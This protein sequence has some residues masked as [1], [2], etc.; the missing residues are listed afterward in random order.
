MSGLLSN[1]DINS[2]GCVI[3]IMN[4]TEKFDNTIKWLVGSKPNTT[5]NY[6]LPVF[7][8][9]G[10]YTEVSINKIIYEYSEGSPIW[11]DW[12]P[13]VTSR[14]VLQ[15]SLDEKLTLEIV[16]TITDYTVAHYRDYDSYSTW[17]Y[18]ADFGGI[19]FMI[20]IL[21]KLVMNILSFCVPND[22]YILGG[23]TNEE[24]ASLIK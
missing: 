19:L 23:I 18:F 17:Q 6:T 2:L 12:H 24:Q 15:D 20:Y 14:T 16:I 9:T 4:T 13:R 11:V 5:P 8:D 3:Q 10:S 22:S 1:P 21:H 7:V